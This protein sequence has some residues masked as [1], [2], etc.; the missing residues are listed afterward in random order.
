MMCNLLPLQADDSVYQQLYDQNPNCLQQTT[1]Q[2]CKIRKPF[3]K[4]VGYS[5]FT[6]S[7]L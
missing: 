1:Y 7:T 6:V 3:S 4:S 5:C 2:N